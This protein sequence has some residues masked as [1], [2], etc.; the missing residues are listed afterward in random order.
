MQI[1]DTKKFKNYY[2]ALIFLSIELISVSL[3]R[4]YEKE[5]SG[6]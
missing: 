5:V 1:F 4:I 2:F 6:Q 3:L